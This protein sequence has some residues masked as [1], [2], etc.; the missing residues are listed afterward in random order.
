[1]L[2]TIHGGQRALRPQARFGGQPGLKI[3]ALRPEMAA[4]LYF[5][6]NRPMSPSR[7]QYFPQK[8]PISTLP[9]GSFQ[10]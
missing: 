8:F 6:V 3:P 4:P 10:H 1:M 9:Q 5:P 2:L 7:A